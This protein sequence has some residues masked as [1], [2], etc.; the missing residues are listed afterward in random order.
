MKHFYIFLIF[1]NKSLVIVGCPVPPVPQDWH[2][3]IGYLE[4]IARGNSDS[5]SASLVGGNTESNSFRLF[6]V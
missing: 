5:I 6:Y 3:L 2:A 1:H 4:S